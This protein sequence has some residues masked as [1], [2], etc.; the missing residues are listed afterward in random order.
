M[1]EPDLG[2]VLTMGRFIRHCADRFGDADLVVRGEQRLTYRAA[3]S[4][5]RDLAK[6]LVSGG[7]TKSSRVGILYDNG[8]EWLVAWFAAARIG[9]LTVPMSTYYRPPEIRRTLRHAD[10]NVLLMGQRL[11]DESCEDRLELAVP[12]LRDATAPGPH[13]LPTTPMLRAAWV[14]GD[15]V[16]PWATDFALVAKVVDDAFIEEIE[17][18]VV[19]SD[20]LSVIYTSGSTADPKGVIHSHAAII[21][22]AARVGERREPGLFAGDRVYCPMP[23]FWVGGLVMGLMTAM[24]AGAT[25]YCVPR[26]DAEQVLELMERERITVVLGFPHASKALAD[27]PSYAARDLSSLR[28]PLDGT[29]APPRHN[30]LGMTETCGTHAMGARDV[31]P[32]TEE[33]Q[34]S[35]GWP[36]EGYEHKIVDPETGA[37]VPDGVEG[38]I[39][40]RGD[41]LMLGMVKRDRNDVFDADGYYHTSDW[42]RLD[43][44]LL[45]FTGRVGE[46]IKSSGMNVAPR[47]VELVFEAMPEVA[48][49]VVV[50]L[51]DPLTGQEVAAAVVPVP[52]ASIDEDSLLRRAKEQLSSYKLPRRL[53]VVSA[54]DLPM[55]DSGKVDRAAVTRMLDA[56]E[57]SERLRAGYPGSQ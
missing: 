49:A 17:A 44:G 29:M 24:H 43:R 54:G 37:R 26:F 2:N 55:R 52:G 42:G 20:P 30:T 34:A 1:V 8:P 35:F 19:P 18:D 13:F 6:Q 51:G 57:E 4:Q 22:H 45:Y 21:R 25:I 46:M 11:F 50:G 31:E 41:D 40:V 33:E 28:K 5:S 38:E 9:A 7:V 39:C 36:I 14:S 27:H 48:M 23:F 56:S 53:R 10:V 15:D 3:E 47:E 16:R 32:L 12:E